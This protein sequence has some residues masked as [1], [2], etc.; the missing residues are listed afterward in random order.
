MNIVPPL[1]ASSKG[2]RIPG[3]S[4]FIDPKEPVACAIISHAHG[5]HAVEGHETVYCSEGTAALIKSRFKYAAKTINIVSF[6]EQFTVQ[7]IPF[8]LHGAGHMLGSSQIKWVKDGITHVYTGDYKRELD[9]SCEPFEIV[10]C[11]VLITEVTFGKENK[12]HPPAEESVAALSK[13]KDVNLMLGAYNLGKSQRLT[14]LI[15][16]IHPHLRVMVHPK[17]IAYHKIYESMGF[18]LGK[19]EPY[20]REQFKNEKGIIYLVPPPVLLNFRTG[21]HFLRAFATGWDEK[22]SRYDFPFYVSDHSDWP[23]LIKTILESEAKIVYTIHGIGEDLK[24]APELK[25]VQVYTLSE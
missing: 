7:D 17:M 1:D 10:K 21:T 2:F 13:Y 16:D 20:K 24:T 5:D 19:W 23:S 6:G 12:I 9:K 14:R 25:S 18:D 8:S 15:N 3:T 4:I 11:D 22:H